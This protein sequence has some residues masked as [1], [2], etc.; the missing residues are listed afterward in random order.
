MKVLFIVPYP[1][2]G[3]SNRYRVEQ[4]L[5]FLDKQGIYWRLRPFIASKFYRILYKKGNTIKKCVYFLAGCIRRLTDI[6]RAVNYDI[7]FI[8]IET[9]PF[10]PPLLEF[11]FYV[12]GKPIVFDFEDAIYLSSPGKAGILR[13]MRFPGK[14]YSN[15]RLSA[16]I[17][18]CNNYLKEKLY[19][20]N[21]NITVIPTSIDTDKFKLKPGKP[22]NDNLLIGWIGSHT[23]LSCLKQIIP[24]LEKL[25][26]KYKFT[27]KIVGGG[28]GIE[29]PGIKVINQKWALEK[30]VESF[31][32]LDIGIYPLPDNEWAMA[33]T[34]FKTI[35][36]MSVGVPTVASAVG[37]NREII[38][39]G[40]NGFLASCE[41]EWIQKLSFLIERPELRRSIG[42]AGRETVE[43]RY[44]LKINA[45][46]FVEVLNSVYNKRRRK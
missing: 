34:P 44:S 21:P 41:E 45:P 40:V 18:V 1:T 37:G 15:I 28:S 8:H 19:C 38:Q 16:R 35:Q 25:G 39:D 14:F 11:I 42:M 31:Q 5:P 30:D 22:S 43:K 24:V 17:I 46:K 20:Y 3:P 6:I 36:Y 12:M 32:S 2:E 29:I 10:G 27:L 4:Y 33:K 7:I 9:F 13:W 26:K 23:T